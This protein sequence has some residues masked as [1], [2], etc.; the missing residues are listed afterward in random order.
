[1][2]RR[3]DLPAI[4]AA[5]LQCCRIGA[6][7]SDWNSIGATQVAPSVRSSA[8]LSAGLPVETSRSLVISTQ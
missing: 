1:M 5:I 4:Q 3:H 8:T 2:N 6:T 7:E